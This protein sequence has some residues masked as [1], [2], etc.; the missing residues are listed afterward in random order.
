MSS[1]GSSFVQIKHEDLLY[2]ENCG[3]GSFGSVY[4][5]LWI[6]QDKEVAVKKL[7]KIDK[8]VRT[9]QGIYPTPKKT[10][11]LTHCGSKL[12]PVPT[13]EPPQPPPLSAVQYVYLK[14]TSSSSSFSSSSSSLCLL[15]PVVVAQGGRCGLHLCQSPPL[16][17]P[18]TIVCL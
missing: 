3:G 4:R 13:A 2:Y 1:P 18:T 11:Y 10:I 9:L 8:E 7:L 6:S 15:H 14:H 16:P 5:A 17:P 12:G